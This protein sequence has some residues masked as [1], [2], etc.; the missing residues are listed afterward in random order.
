MLPEYPSDMW[1]S[2]N[3][4]RKLSY[5][6]AHDR[7]SK[8]AQERGDTVNGSRSYVPPDPKLYCLDWL[9]YVGEDEPHEYMR[10][11]YPVWHTVLRHMHFTAN[12]HRIADD[13][14]RQSLGLS[15]KD[16][17]PEV[18]HYTIPCDNSEEAYL[19]S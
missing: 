6:E 3:R 19:S 17:I 8:A 11:W 4:L 13:H 16:V 10:D 1:S 14:L 18:Q 5:P 12:F 2:M 15:N 9:Y 7:E